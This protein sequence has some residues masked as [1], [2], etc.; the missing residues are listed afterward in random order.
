MTPKYPATIILLVLLILTSAFTVQ[1]QENKFNLMPVPSEIKI[2]KG[3]FL[4]DS[5]FAAC[6]TG[7][8]DPRIHNAASRFL[9]RLA[10]RT[11]LFIQQDFVI[12]REKNKHSVLFIQVERPGRLIVGED[13][14][15]TLKIEDDEIIVSAVTDLGAMH[16]LET[17][18]QLL[19]GDSE[20]YFFPEV[21]IKDAPRFPWRGLMIDVSRHFFPLDLI[22]RNL[23]AMA[24]VK[25]N[26]FHWHLSDDQG[27]RVESK[28]YPK[29]HELGSDGI[30]YTQEEIKA[31]VKY[32][33]D[34][35]IR[36]IPEFDVPGHSSAFL[37]AYPEFASAPG[38]YKI[39]RRWGIFDP[40]FDPT[41]EKTYEFFDRFFGEMTSLFPDEYFH[42][43]GDENNGRQWDNNKNIQKFMKDNNIKD[44]HELQAYF[45]KR[46]VDI[47][48]KYNKKMVGWDEIL[49]PDM[50]KNILI[51]SWRGIKSLAESARHGYQG[52]LS[53]GYYIDLVQPASFHYLNDPIPDSLNLSAEE[54][55]F[56]LGGEATSWAELVTLETVESRI[57]PRTAVIAERLWSPAYVRDVDDMYKRLER[58][59]FLLEEHGLLHQKN[60]EMMLRRLT[61]NHDIK[62][63][64]TIA[65]I[66][67]PVKIYNRHFQGK[68]HVQHSPYTR[69]V[70]AARPESMTAREFNLLVDKYIQTKDAPVLDILRGMLIKWES[71]H[72]ELVKLMEVSP[73]IKEL[74]P[75]SL[76]LVKLSRTALDALD[77]MTSNRLPSNEW[78]EQS[79]LAIE[80]AKKP[81][82]QTEFAI[83][84]AVEKLLKH[85]GWIK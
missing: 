82:G 28:V 24:A 81:H 13:E 10:N 42:I 46:L 21:E 73:I 38:P 16:G 26:V 30:Y 43:G 8:A 37:T 78:L 23:D 17:L 54:K 18:L 4:L 69:T 22:R 15:Y 58:M 64:K 85:N 45:N 27:I 20:G 67:E 84:G 1:A 75:H 2:G 31:L 40:T 14:S 59:S 29:L 25:M 7:T 51:Q 62:A 35:G 65:D 63:L 3:H 72:A 53:N 83:T 60:Y 74:E 49:N 5:T 56:I 44:N 70:D 61:D 34:R 9:R 33:A 77:L 57:W 11:G 68:V 19:K 55:K 52:I 6:V 79:K 12:P 76:N 80:N 71:N 47:L 41:I 48:N 39:E 36:V 66:L 50:P 32:A